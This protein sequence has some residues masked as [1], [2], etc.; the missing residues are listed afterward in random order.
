MQAAAHPQR[1]ENPLA[2]RR[3][4]GA[5]QLRKRLRGGLRRIGAGEVS[6]YIDGPRGVVR[7]QFPS[8]DEDVRVPVSE[9]LA[10]LSALPKGA[11]TEAAVNALRARA[12]NTAAS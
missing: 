3:V 2:P 1:A 4:R 6:L 11:G 9:G 7:L 10:L 5:A 12:L 8:Q